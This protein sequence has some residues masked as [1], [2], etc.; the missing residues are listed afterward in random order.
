MKV[1]PACNRRPETGDFPCRN[2]TPQAQRRDV[3][4]CGSLWQAS[5]CT[6]TLHR[7]PD[8]SAATRGRIRSPLRV[9]PHA[10][11]RSLARG[12]I[13]KSPGATTLGTRRKEHEF[14]L[15]YLLHWLWALVALT[16]LG[17]SPPGSVQSPGA[18]NTSTRSRGNAPNGQKIVIDLSRRESFTL[19][20]VNAD[21]DDV[22]VTD[23]QVKHLPSTYHLTPRQGD[24]RLGHSVDIVLEK[25]SNVRIRLSLVKRGR[26]LALR[27][28]PQI[29]FGPGDTVELTYSRIERTARTLHRRLKDQR[30]RLS[31]LA[32]EQ[33]SLEI[34]LVSPANKPLQTVK[35]VRMRLKILEQ[36]LQAQQ[37]QLPVMVSRCVVLGQIA[38]FA[39]Q[40]HKRTEI[41]FQAR[42]AVK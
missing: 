10:A 20:A 15:T 24:V 42:A 21:P 18:R 29:V 11:A 9:Q 31:T 40:L 7:R 41:H 37:R 1:Q 5:R 12:R 39:H 38:D 19:L 30:Q 35:T 25:P 17:A 33:R 36:E 16:L 23:V 2:T 22:R 3:S 34:W 26:Q 28:S 32:R 27:V 4:W 14:S 13:G 6:R 8:C